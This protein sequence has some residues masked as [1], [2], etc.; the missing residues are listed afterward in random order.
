MSPYAQSPS[1]SGQSGHYKQDFLSQ[2]PDIPLA[3][4]LQELQD[5]GFVFDKPEGRIVE[6]AANLV[7]SHKNTKDILAFYA[8][9][10]P[11][12]G[13]IFMKGDD[14]KG[15]Q[16]YRLGEWLDIITKGELVLFRLQPAKK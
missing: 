11:N 4:G 5:E 6:I 16:Y 1:L 9:T 3:Q 14:I 2:A 13:W 8:K 15:A 12:L 7:E 10:L